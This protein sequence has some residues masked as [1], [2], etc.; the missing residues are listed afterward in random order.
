MAELIFAFADRQALGGSTYQVQ[1]MGRP[2]TSVWEGWI[3][4]VAP[5]GARLQT[6]RETTQ[7]N[8]E[9]LEYWASGLSPTYLEGAFVRATNA[10][11]SGRGGS[12]ARQ[13]PSPDFRERRPPGDRAVLDPYSVGAK[14]EE[15]LRSE[16]FALSAWH[17]RNIVRAYALTDADVN[18]EALSQ[19]QLVELIVDGVS[20]T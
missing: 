4:F 1:V 3:D 17:L 15:L 14:G 20:V 9:A 10:S 13:D 2:M 8:R 16:L 12:N 19:A 5:D 18:L 6:P 7:P 11:V